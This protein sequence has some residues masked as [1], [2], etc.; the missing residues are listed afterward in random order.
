MIVG[1]TQYPF[2]VTV[3]KQDIFWTDWTTRSVYRASKDDGSDV[4]VLREGLQYRP[5]DIHVFSSSKQE[6]CASPCQQFNGGCSHVCV[7]GK[8]VCVCVCE[9][10]CMCVCVTTCRCLVIIPLRYSQRPSHG[11]NMSIPPRQ[12]NQLA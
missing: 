7:P 4:A 5:N 9:C 3:Y 12:I 2:A 6:T 10:V 8:V 11:T 1:L